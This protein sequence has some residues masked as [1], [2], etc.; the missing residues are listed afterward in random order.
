MPRTLSSARLQILGAAALFS[1]GGAAIK[2]AAFSAPQVSA[3]RSGIAAIALVMW[4]RGRLQWSGTAVLV[5]AVYA[6]TLTLFVAATKL[7]T[8]ANAIFLQS[9]APLYLL[10]LAPAVLR[11]RVHRRDAAYMIA[12][13]AGLL[14]CFFGQRVATATAPDPR[15][16]NLLAV[17][18]G[19]AWALT[20]LGFR[21]TERVHARRGVSLTAV[22][23]GNG[24]AFLVALPYAWPFPSTGL[25]EWGTVLYLGIFQI[26]LAYV[27]VTSAM[28]HLPALDASLLLLLEP[29]LNPVWAWAIRGEEPGSWAL[30]GGGVIL[31]ATAIKSVFDARTIADRRG[32]SA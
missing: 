30:L 6:A 13:A 10:L 16:G 28:R 12:V 22:V 29:V 8:A 27:F 5:G 21:W 18:C 25:V 4:L 15:A 17:G 19:V 7:T 26:G 31:G 11:E 1:T 3:L 23:A 20:L 24:I 32:P 9:T 14:L 2:V